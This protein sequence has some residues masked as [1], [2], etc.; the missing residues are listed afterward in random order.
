M[1]PWGGVFVYTNMSANGTI[2]YDNGTA[3]MTGM[4]VLRPINS[5]PN[6]TAIKGNTTVIAGQTV[7]LTIVASDSNNHTL[8]YF[9]NATFGM[10]NSTTGVFTWPTNSSN[11]GNRT[12]TFI[13]SDG[14]TSTATTINITILPNLP[15]NVTA[16]IGNTTVVA[17]GLVNLT[18][19]VTDPNNL[20]VIFGTNVPIV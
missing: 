5:A 2:A 20:T 13:V 4:R 9:T 17:G 14:L 10:L 18:I 7:N 6:I 3:I 19:R 11:V 1:D 8:M 12:I 15:P 16:V